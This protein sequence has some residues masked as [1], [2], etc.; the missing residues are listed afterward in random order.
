MISIRSRGIQKTAVMALISLFAFFCIIPAI[1]PV[2]AATTVMI[3]EVELNPIGDDNLLHDGIKEQIELYNPTSLPISLSGWSVQTINGVKETLVIGQ[4]TLIPAGGYILIGRDSQW[5]DNTNETVVLRDTK[6][7]L[8]DSAG[9]RNDTNNDGQSWQRFPNGAATWSFRPSTL[10]SWNDG[11]TY[12]I[13]HMNDVTASGGRA[14]NSAIPIRAE[15]VNTTS[16]LVGQNIDQITMR[17][18]RVG[19]PTGNATIGVFASSGN[20][21]RQF[22]SIDVASVGTGFADYTFSLSIP[23]LYTIQAQDRI[24]IKFSG[25]ST[26]NYVNVMVDANSADPFNGINSYR[27]WFTTS[28][29]SFTGEDMYMI[30]K[31]SHAFIPIIYMNDNTAS[32]GRPLYSSISIRGEFVSPTSQL[33]GDR[34]DQI[35][36]QLAKVGTPTGNAVAGI[37]DSTGILK[38]QFGTPQN[39]ATIGTTFSNYVFALESAEHYTLQ[40]G[41]RIGIKYTGGNATKYVNVMVDANSADPFD[42]ANSYRQWFTTSWQSYT[43]EDMFMNL[44]QTQ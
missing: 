13:I 9:P 25:G 40:P 5:L 35:T 11:T 38:R 44:K 21:L 14:L 29:Q 10:G 18:A 4:P 19:S 22:G 42:G 37:F 15:Y 6:G 33:I 7:A 3:N 12:P 23:Q 28:W 39:V 32:G 20:L 24:G 36:L 31:Q 30:L 34:I 2:A 41:D 16:Q 43:N 26:V 1:P 27:Q 17:L 8:I